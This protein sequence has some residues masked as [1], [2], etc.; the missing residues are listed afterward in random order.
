MKKKE[1]TTNQL[2]EAAFDLFA[3]HGLE[4]TSLGMIASKVGIT[5]PSIYY[6]FSSKE[7]LISRT[8]DHIFK[9]HHYDKY[10]QTDSITKEN[11]IETLYQRGLVMLPDGNKEHF[12]VLRVLGEFMMLAEREEIYRERLTNMHQEFLNGFRDLLLKGVSYG[13][14]SSQTTDNKAYMLA[15]VIDNISRC[16]M[17]KFDMNY[18]DV[19]KETVNSVLIEEARAEFQK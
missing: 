18:Q 12:A 11:F 3:E 7:E 13:V 9:D 2:I 5:K 10:F 14:V 16:M 1:L 8:F 15:L 6:H 17:M 19:W 4:R